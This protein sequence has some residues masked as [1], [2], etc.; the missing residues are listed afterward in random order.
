MDDATATI[1]G[2]A[3]AQA[4]ARWKRVYVDP[5]VVIDEKAA[6]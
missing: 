5:Y 1:G 6:D 4:F 2:G 3:P